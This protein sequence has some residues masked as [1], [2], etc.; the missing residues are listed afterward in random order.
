MK[1]AIIDYGMGNLTSVQN[2]LV[3]LGLDAT[4]VQ[5]AR[6]IKNHD[7]LILPGVG[8]FGHA[9]KNLESSG[10]KEALTEEVLNHKKP[11]L[12]LCLGMQLLFESS[13]EHGTH[14]GFGWI[15]GHVKNLA[16]LVSGIPVPHVGWNDVEAAPGSMLLKNIPQ[17]QNVYYFVHS[18]ACFSEERDTVKGTV[19]YGT[20]FDVVVE[21]EN[22]YGCQF[23]PEKSQKSGLQILQNFAGL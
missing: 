1:I 10:M 9:M 23:H 20:T 12:G 21:K 13:N 2:A 18:Y 6:E 19:S 17:A 16:D 8:A 4:R 22:I 5:D 7:K 11:L 14:A 3:F 15:K